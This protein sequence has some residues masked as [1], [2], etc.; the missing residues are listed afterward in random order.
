LINIPNDVTK[1]EE[2]PKDNPTAE[3]QTIKEL[4]LRVR[5]VEEENAAYKL[6]IEQLLSNK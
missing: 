3:S 4:N 1:T 6:K 5:E 2:K